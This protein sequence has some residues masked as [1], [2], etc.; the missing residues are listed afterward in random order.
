[1]HFESD[2]MERGKMLEPE[3]FA[4][5]DIQTDS[6]PLKVG[7]IYRDEGRMVGCSPD[8]LVPGKWVTG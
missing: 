4:Y 6:N 1:M 8:G 3:A 2:W 7:F 5:Y